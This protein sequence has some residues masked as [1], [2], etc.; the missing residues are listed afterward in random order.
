MTRNKESLGWWNMI[1]W[2]SL[3]R[4]EEIP[5]GL[6]ANK[7]P[8]AYAQN[9]A[10]NLLEKVDWQYL[11][12]HIINLLLTISHKNGVLLFIISK[13]MI[14]LSN[15]GSPDS[16]FNW[17]VTYFNVLNNK[18]RDPLSQKLTIIILNKGA[19]IIL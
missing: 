7:H 8:Q 13:I 11:M 18:L 4:V 2:T 16:M 17:I 14:H 19:S 5:N 9:Y 15:N 10:T 6:W 3:L 1:E 12:D